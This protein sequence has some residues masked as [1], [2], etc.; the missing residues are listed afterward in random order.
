MARTIA[1]SLLEQVQALKNKIDEVM[2]SHTD[3]NEEFGDYME[4]SDH[5]EPDPVVPESSQ[6]QMVVDVH[7]QPTLMRMNPLW[8]SSK[9]ME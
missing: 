8:K 6:V 3:K 9:G 1:E 5:S 2:L 7:E 4:S